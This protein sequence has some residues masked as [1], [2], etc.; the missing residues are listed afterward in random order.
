MFLRADSAGA[1]VSV[2]GKDGYKLLLTTCEN[3]LL[4][5]K[6]QLQPHLP[7]DTQLHSLRLW[8]TENAFAEWY[9]VDI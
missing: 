9:A 1:L 5:I 6:G 7:E 2:L 3:L 4:Y 8:E